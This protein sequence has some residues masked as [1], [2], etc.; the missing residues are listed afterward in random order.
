MYKYCKKHI[1]MCEQVEEDVD[2][3]AANGKLWW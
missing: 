1:H 3:A 2:D